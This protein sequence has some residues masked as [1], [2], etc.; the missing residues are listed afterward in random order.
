VEGVA[1]SNWKPSGKSYEISKREVKDAWEQ[2]KAN[3]GA[4]GADGVTLSDFEVI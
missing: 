2:V 1:M 4:P 3:K